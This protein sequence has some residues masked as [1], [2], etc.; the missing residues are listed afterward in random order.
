MKYLN[1]IYIRKNFNNKIILFIQLIIFLYSIYIINNKK[2]LDESV[3]LITDKTSS[4]WQIMESKNYSSELI[5]NLS[6]MKYI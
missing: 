3:V 4:V 2:C 6:F 1:L 5:T